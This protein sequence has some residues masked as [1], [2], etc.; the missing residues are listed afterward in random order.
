[1]ARRVQQ[2]NSHVL[3]IVTNLHSQQAWAK[4]N[5]RHA[6]CMRSDNSIKE[7]QQCGG[8][9]TSHDTVVNVVEKQHRQ[10]DTAA[11]GLAYGTIYSFRASN[12]LVQGVAELPQTFGAK[13]FAS[14]S[15]QHAKASLSHG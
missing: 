11:D 12:W 10:Q 6:V 1:M 4:S 8:W 2:F 9:R 5:V 7:Q 13:L 3:M 15:R 14:I